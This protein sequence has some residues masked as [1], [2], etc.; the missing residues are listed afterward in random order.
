MALAHVLA[1]A[2][3]GHAV[4][5]QAVIADLCR[6]ADDDTHAVVND[7]T[8]ADLGAGMNLN[9]GT[10]AAAL[11]DQPGQKFQPMLITPVGFPV[12]PYGSHAG[13]QQQNLKRTAGSRVSGL[14]GL[15]DFF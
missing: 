10:V 9:A 12:A 5:N 8:L 15:N 3:Q 6:L 13:V 2:A 11:G 7:Q 14:I 1:G 4:V